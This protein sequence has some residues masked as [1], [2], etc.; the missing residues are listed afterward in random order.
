[1]KRCKACGEL[2]SPE[3]YTQVYCSVACRRWANGEGRDYRKERDQKQ[4]RKSAVRQDPPFTW[5]QITETMNENKCQYRRALEILEERRQREKG[6][7]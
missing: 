6:I 4:K 3:F 2:F 1:M 5:S 7:L